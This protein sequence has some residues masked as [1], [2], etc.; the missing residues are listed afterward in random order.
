MSGEHLV[1]LHT[2]VIINCWGKKVDEEN[3]NVVHSN[4]YIEGEK[5]L[6]FLCVKGRYLANIKTAPKN[7][8][9]FQ[10]QKYNQFLQKESQSPIRFHTLSDKN[11]YTSLR[12]ISLYFISTG[13]YL[14]RQDKRRY[15]KN[16][17]NLNKNYLKLD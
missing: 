13:F 2:N 7:T 17:E 1:E 9:A 5:I 11:V 6:A 3:P 12:S 16:Y 14:S 8:E 4:S 15:T 10:M